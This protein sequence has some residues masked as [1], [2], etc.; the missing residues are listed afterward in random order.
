MIG[1]ACM[2]SVVWPSRLFSSAFGVFVIVIQFIAPLIIL[3]YCNGRIVWVLTRRIDSNIDN[4]S[5]NENQLN[6][7]FLLART[8]TIKTFL[9]VGIFFY[10][11]L[12]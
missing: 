7:K 10:Y 9:L 8:N 4:L 11:L 2:L 5:S 1:N 6:S 3:V 12:D